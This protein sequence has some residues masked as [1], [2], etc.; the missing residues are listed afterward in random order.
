MDI[1]TGYIVKFRKHK[2]NNSK[3]ITGGFGII[4]ELCSDKSHITEEPCYK[5]N[6]RGC[7]AYRRDEIIH[8]PESGITEILLKKKMIF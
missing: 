7:P 8:V 1:R 2:P 3:I 6:V 5:V 4:D